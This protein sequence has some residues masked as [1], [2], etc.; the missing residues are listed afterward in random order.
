MSKI[1][2]ATLG[3]LG[4]VHPYIAVG[5]ALTQ[6]GHQAVIATSEEYQAPIERAGVG[7]AAVPPSM[8]Q[9]GD[10]QTLVGQVLNVRR[11]PE[12]LIR[13]LVMP[14]LS[15]AYD[16]LWRHSE[17]AD[18]LVSHPLSVTMPL[19]AQ[20]RGLPW[21]ATVLAPMSLMSSFDPPT[22]ANAPWFRKLR[23]LGVTPY[24]LAFNLAKRQAY[25]WERPLRDFRRELG[26]PPQKALALFEGQFSPHLNLALFDPPLAS[27]QPDWPP[28]TRVCGSPTYDGAEPEPALRDELEQFLSLGEPPIVFA[29]GSSAVWVA[30]DFWQHAVAAAERLHRRAILITGPEPPGALPHGVKAYPYL[31][32]SLVFPRAAV[33]VHQAGI[34]TLA[35]A[36][37]SGRPQL[38]VPV[39]FDQPDNARRTEL[40]GVGRSLAF[41]KVTTDRLVALLSPLLS[42]SNYSAA[43]AD[44]ARNLARTDPAARAADE[45]LAA[46]GVGG[47]R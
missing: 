12:F 5:R 26:L 1:L 14:Y 15:P 4:D 9:L 37:R 28:N 41:K 31:P 27:P 30:G 25:G 42:N 21:A 18:L 8:A 2:F 3:S 19:V 39:A 47:S 20:K 35:Q 10:Y 33:V 11:G 7:F 45:L 43:A 36:M 22:I 34:G 40:L 38:L 29:L 44:L 23:A 32:Y 13:R 24:R 6:R 17:R 16:Q 46:V